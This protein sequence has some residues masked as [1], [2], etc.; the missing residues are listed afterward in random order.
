[1][2]HSALPA[3]DVDLEE[4]RADDREGAVLDKAVNAANTDLDEA[5]RV[6]VALSRYPGEGRDR[7]PESTVR[8]D[9]SG[10]PILVGRR[11]FQ[12][13]APG[14]FSHSAAK[15]PCSPWVRLQSDQGRT[16]WST[17]P[18]EPS[19]TPDIGADVDD[20]SRPP[21]DGPQDGCGRLV[22]RRP[23]STRLPKH[24]VVR[25][26]KATLASISEDPP[27]CA[28]RECTQAV[29]SPGSPLQ[30]IVHPF[31]G[32]MTGPQL[33][34]REAVSDRLPV[35]ARMPMPQSSMTK[36]PRSSSR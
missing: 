30:N 7:T 16:W 2:Q 35:S 34:T 9:E 20:G 28:T 15:Q 31:V 3:L 22:F 14:E 19:V 8:N 10:G 4:D 6:D 33:S 1:V 5:R 12:D 32:Q 26:V 25:I 29:K 13:R 36:T 27:K 18:Q 21:S 23:E 17:P 11:K 24:T